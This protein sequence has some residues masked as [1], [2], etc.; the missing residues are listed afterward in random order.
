MST[1]TMFRIGFILLAL[2]VSTADSE[3]LLVPL[4]LAFGGL[5]L[6]LKAQK[7]EEGEKDE[8]GSSETAR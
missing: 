3:I 7:T 5:W 4:A 8:E 6:M 2:G 1:T